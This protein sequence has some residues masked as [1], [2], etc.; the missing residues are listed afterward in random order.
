MGV[1]ASGDDLNALVTALDKENIYDSSLNVPKQYDEIIAGAVVK[2]QTKYGI[3]ASGWVGP[4][5]R[6][7][8]NALYGCANSTQEPSTPVLT[9][10]AVTPQ[11]ASLTVGSTQQLTAAAYDQNGNSLT[12]TPI[13]WTSSN[14]GVATVNQYGLVTPVNAGTTTITAYSGSVTSNGVAVTFTAGA[15]TQSTVPTFTNI[16]PS[17]VTYT[18]GQTMNISWQS[19]GL[20]SSDTI[21]LYLVDTSKTP[22]QVPWFT[23]VTGLRNSVTSYQW[24]PPNPVPVGNYYKVRV[25]T[26]EPGVQYAGYSSDYI[27]VVAPGTSSFLAISGQLAS[28][29]DSNQL[30]SLLNAISNYLQQQG[31]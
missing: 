1:G 8:L 18:Q 15:N 11:S 9:R 2:F 28:I 6:A 21:N 25:E 7:K 16:A 17:G 29:L 22:Q 20:A 3:R 26:N 4:V 5:T 27:K 13:W 24:N 30:S 23:I 19:A 12:S 10:I 31:Q 14:P